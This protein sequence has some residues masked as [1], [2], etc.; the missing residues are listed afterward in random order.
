MELK[1][2]IKPENLVY[3]KSKVQVDTIMHYCPGCSHGV[4]HKV[5]A[6][7]IEEGRLKPNKALEE[8]AKEAM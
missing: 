5:L 7:L 2:I 3:S 1:D 6:E 4:V 8:T